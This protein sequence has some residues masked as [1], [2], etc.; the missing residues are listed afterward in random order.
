MECHLKITDSRLYINGTEIWTI[1]S[2]VPTY[3]ACPSRCMRC[4]SRP[5][6]CG[7]CFRGPYSHGSYSHDSYSRGPYC[8]DSC[9]HGPYHDEPCAYRGTHFLYY[10][11]SCDGRETSGIKKRILRS[12]CVSINS[13]YSIHVYHSKVFYIIF[14]MDVTKEISKSISFLF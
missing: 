14:I 10:S 11:W 12:L 4:P 13:I 2:Y 1:G 9:S 5:R 7:S 6:H 8:R 3:R